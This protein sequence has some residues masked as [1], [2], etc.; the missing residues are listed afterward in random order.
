MFQ[1]FLFCLSCIQAK[2][3]PRATLIKATT[4]WPLGPKNLCWSPSNDIYK[5][6]SMVGCVS[7]SGQERV[8]ILCT[9]SGYFKSKIAWEGQGHT[10][11]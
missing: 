11:H 1:L 4:A 8:I 9:S 3:N 2:R 5:A 10:K 6:S 7:K